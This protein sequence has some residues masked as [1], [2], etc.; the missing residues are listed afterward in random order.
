M[1]VSSHKV[2]RTRFQRRC[3]KDIVRCVVQDGRHIFVKAWQKDAVPDRGGRELARCAAAP[4]LSPSAAQLCWAGVSL[5]KEDVAALKA[6]AVQRRGVL[7]DAQVV[8]GQPAVR[9]SSR[10]SRSVARCPRA[11]GPCTPRPEAWN[12]REGEKTSGS[13]RVTSPRRSKSLS[14]LISWRIPLFNMVAA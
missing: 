14:V 12:H 9:Q 10:R 8:E 3:E 11:P 5:S 13:M 4:S 1:R 6:G 7:L 2:I